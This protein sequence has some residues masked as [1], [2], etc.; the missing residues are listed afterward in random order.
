V[1]LWSASGELWYVDYEKL[2]E[3][4]STGRVI[5]HYR[6]PEGCY[7]NDVATTPDGNIWYYDSADRCIGRITPSGTVTTVLTYNRKGGYT[8]SPGILYGPNND[9]WFNEPGNKGLGWIDPKT[10]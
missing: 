3:V 9:I 10:M 5:A 6:Y 7:P 4:S 1:P 2:Y 8:P